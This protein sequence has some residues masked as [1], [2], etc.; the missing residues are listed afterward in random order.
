M[1]HGG[2]AAQQEEPDGR[3]FQDIENNRPGAAR[4]R[5]GEP[6]GAGRGHRAERREPGQGVHG[7]GGDNRHCADKAGRHPKGRRGVAHQA[8]AGSAGEVRRR[9]GTDRRPAAL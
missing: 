9:G 8:G 5:P 7:R 3:A 4:L 6:A 2:A 1:R